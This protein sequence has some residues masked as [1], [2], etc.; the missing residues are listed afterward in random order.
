PLFDLE[1][2]ME[3]VFSN[4]DRLFGQLEPDQDRPEDIDVGDP[5]MFVGSLTEG[6][7]ESGVWTCSVGG[8]PE[9]DYAVNEVMVMVAGRLRITNED[10]SVHE[11]SAGDMFFLPKGWAGRWDVLEDMKKIYFIVE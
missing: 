11:L 3:A 9:T 2:T 6:A 10:G 8:W 4:V 5:E 7:I 1:V